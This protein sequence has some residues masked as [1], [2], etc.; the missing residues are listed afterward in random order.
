M[1]SNLGIR[2]EIIGGLDARARMRMCPHEVIHLYDDDCF[3]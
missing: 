1:C 3:G 2:S